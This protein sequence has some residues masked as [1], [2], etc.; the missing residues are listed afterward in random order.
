MTEIRRLS[1]GIIERNIV[2]AGDTKA[3]RDAAPQ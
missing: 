3:A 1:Q 2:D